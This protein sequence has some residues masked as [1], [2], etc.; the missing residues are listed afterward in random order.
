MAVEKK[1][2]VERKEGGLVGGRHPLVF[3]PFP[4]LAT[5]CQL[6]ASSFLLSPLRYLAIRVKSKKGQKNLPRKEGETAEIFFL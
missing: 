1:S 4:F 5:V 3:T 6:P 2:Q